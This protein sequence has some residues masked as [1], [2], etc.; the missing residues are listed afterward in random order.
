MSEPRFL[1]ADVVL[2]VTI[3]VTLIVLSLVSV[4]GST[5]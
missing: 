4:C 2:V 3:A 1:P 5:P